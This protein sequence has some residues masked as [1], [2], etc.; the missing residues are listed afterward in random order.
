M[1]IDTEMDSST[2][3]VT[4]RVADTGPG[5]TPEQL[6]K[7]NTPL[8]GACAHGAGLPGWPGAPPP[9]LPLLAVCVCA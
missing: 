8:T 6:D 7:F 3:L 1:S 5:F 9:L 4:I 2:G